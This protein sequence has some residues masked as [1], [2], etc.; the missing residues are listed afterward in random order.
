MR[1]LFGLEGQVGPVSRSLQAVALALLLLVA[2]CTAPVADGGDG[3]PGQSVTVSLS[4]QHDQRYA[5][6]IVVASGDLEGVRVTYE[7]GSSRT[8]A[9]PNVSALPSAAR[10]NATDLGLLG[11]DLRSER[12]VLAPNSGLGT[13][14]EDVPADSRLVYVVTD[15]GGNGALRS[16]GVSRCAADGARMDFSLEIGPDGSLDVATICTTATTNG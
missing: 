8:Y 12:F 2:G 3:R 1:A 6:R 10:V 14:F 11:E 16:V 4:N 9:V 13:T 5:V 15:A 7:N